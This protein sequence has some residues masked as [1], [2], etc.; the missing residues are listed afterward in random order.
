M[1]AAPAGTMA[2][3]GT[4]QITITWAA[5]NN[6]STYNVYWSSTAGVTITNGNKLANAASPYTHLGLNNGQTYYYIVTAIN[7]KGESSPSAEVSATPALGF[8]WTTRIAGSGCAC[9]GGLKGIVWSG[10]QF[11]AVGSYGVVYTSPDGVQWTMQSTNEPTFHLNDVLWTG[12]DYVAGGIVVVG[13]NQNGFPI[14]SPMFLISTDGVTWTRRTATWD[15]QS[16][17]TGDAT[18]QVTSIAWSGTSFVA[19]MGL[20]IYSSSD[21]VAW[22]YRGNAGPARAVWSNNQFLLASQQDGTLKNSLDGVTWQ[23]KLTLG[24]TYDL[25]DIA[26]SGSKFAGAGVG[27]AWGLIARS[28][29]L[30]SWSVLEWA[31]GVATH[32][33]RIIWDGTQFVAVGS[34][35]KDFGNNSTV[36]AVL[37]SSN[38]DDWT[39]AY[40][41]NTF[42]KLLSIASSGT[43]YVVVGD[44]GAILSSP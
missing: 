21:G 41:G 3:T 36:D 4:N 29:D 34:L 32:L 11:V 26:Y 43:R 27:P 40:L 24:S 31:S 28:T 8:S 13:S 19:I 17:V 2:S 6:A 42:H 7:S 35:V 18:T 10:N 44:D 14:Y 15:G 39:E 9:N 25:N 12:A 1:P 30:I 16:I 33:E 5:V 38:G 20:G 22:I 23:T 37:T